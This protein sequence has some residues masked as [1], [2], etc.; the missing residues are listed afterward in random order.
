MYNDVRKMIIFLHHKVIYFTKRKCIEI[1]EINVKWIVSDEEKERYSTALADELPS[2][3]VKVGVSQDE[4]AR[5]IGVSRQTYGDVERKVRPMAWSTFLSLI[6]FFDSHE[7]T[8]KLLRSLPAFPYD[9]WTRFNDGIYPGDLDFNNFAGLTNEDI[10]EQLD[11]QALYTIRTVLMVEYARCSKLSSEAVIKSFD[12]KL[13]NN[14]SEK[15]KQIRETL[16]RIRGTC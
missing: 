3:R 7:A 10:M 2:L 13:F 15:D 14:I 6:L 11:E 1:Q 9:I 8:H 4:L 12:G 16:R 5:I